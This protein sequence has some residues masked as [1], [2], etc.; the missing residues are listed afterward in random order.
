V[1]NVEDSVEIWQ[2][3]RDEWSKSVIFGKEPVDS[4]M[5]SAAQQINQLTG[6]S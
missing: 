5:N 3:F 2:T 6:E 1:P 4:A